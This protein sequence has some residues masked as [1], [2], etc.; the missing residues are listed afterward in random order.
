MSSTFQ[1]E[2]I[3]LTIFGESHG[4]A[5]GVTID[6][7][8]AGIALDFDK[9]LEFMEKKITY[10]ELYEQLDVISVEFT[11]DYSLDDP[12]TNL[13]A[14]SPF[15][16][17]VDVDTTTSVVRAEYKLKTEEKALWDLFEKYCYDNRTNLTDWKILSDT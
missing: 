6:K 8:P 16:I 13:G 4:K 7:M 5:I 11:V 14:L 2:N 3:S 9:I 12:E 10:S 15:I 17:D 1:S